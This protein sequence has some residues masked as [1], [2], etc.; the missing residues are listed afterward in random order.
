MTI[1]RVT[2]FAI[3]IGIARKLYKEVLGP[4]LTLLL[5]LFLLLFINS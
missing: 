5:N 3:K 1:P 2:V 4:W